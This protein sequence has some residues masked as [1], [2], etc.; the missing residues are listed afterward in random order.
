[1]CLPAVITAL[2]P[3]LGTGA[4][5][6]ATG[7][8]AAAGTLAN[9]GTLVSIGG[10][11]AQGVA[12]LNASRQQV[13]AIEAQK[14]TEAELTAIKDQRDRAKFASAIA[15][16][17]AELAARGVSLD[18]VTAVAL[19]RSAAQ[20]MSFDSQA[21][22]AAGTARQTEL[23]AE[24]RAAQAAG[25][26]SILRGT[27]SAAGSLLDGAPDLWPGFMKDETAA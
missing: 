7:A 26:S 12:G 14:R 22:R 23:S 3:L 5:A 11:V 24:Q 9:L 19:G 16:Q 18:S 13:A 2:G 15:Q 20:E 17:R 8:A 6:T 21:T 4:A 1:M 27:F 25:L 10:A